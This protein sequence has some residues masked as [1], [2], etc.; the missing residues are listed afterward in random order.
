MH[1][2]QPEFLPGHETEKIPGGFSAQHPKMSDTL[3]WAT[4]PA[5]PVL[6]QGQ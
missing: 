4:F 5:L 2:S 3:L 6:L 1:F